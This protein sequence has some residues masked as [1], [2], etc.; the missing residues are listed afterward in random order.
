M[1]RCWP[2]EI[3]ERMSVISTPAFAARTSAQFARQMQEFVHALCTDMSA[4]LQR[5]GLIDTDAAMPTSPAKVKGRAARSSALVKSNRSSKAM[6]LATGYT[7]SDARYV[8]EN[9]L[10]ITERQLRAF[11]AT[12]LSVYRRCVIE[13]GTAVGAIGAQSIGEPGTQMTLKTFHFAGVASMNITL[14]VPRIKEIINAAKKITSPIITCPLTNESEVTAARLVK[15]RIERTQLGEIAQSIE[16][17]LKPN[18]CYIDIVL[19]LSCIDLL[20]LTVNCD[21]VIESIMSHKKLKLK[22]CTVFA[23]A[24][25]TVR[26]QVKNDSSDSFDDDLMFTLSRIKSALSDVVV[27]GVSNVDRA[28]INDKG[29]H[30]YE[31]LVEGYNLLGC[32]GTTGVVASR[33]TSNHV[34]EMLRVLGIESARQTIVSEIHSVMSSHGLVIDTRHVQ[35]LADIMSYR[36]TILGITRFGIARMKESVLMLASFEK[37]AD[38]LYEAALR[39]SRDQIKGVSECIIMGTE[40]KIGTGLFQLVRPDGNVTSL[41]AATHQ[42]EQAAIKDNWSNSNLM[43]G[44]GKHLKLKI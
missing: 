19:D 31:L 37:T 34:D 35:L 17:T 29:G 39:S 8:L 20:Q 14:G 32:M 36:G 44:P 40:I 22:K 24:H 15:A 30:K 6:S 4:T 1:R 23:S 33:C 18:E 10:R 27:A 11:L 21:T 42:A 28:V 7:H 13:P 2:D 41:T 16:M 9:T 26:V 38:H 5:V 43:L 3:K 25:D 12:C